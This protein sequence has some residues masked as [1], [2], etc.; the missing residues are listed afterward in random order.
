MKPDKI[1]IAELIQDGVLYP[2]W[3]EQPFKSVIKN[4]EYVSIES[5]VKLMKEMRAKYKDYFF[6][7]EKNKT[8]R[9][10]I[11]DIADQFNCM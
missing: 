3:R 11:D 6:D 7:E 4:H 2:E 10:V 1:Y 9:S 8:A 5:V